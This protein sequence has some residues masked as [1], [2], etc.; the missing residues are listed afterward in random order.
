MALEFIKPVYSAVK[1]VNGQTGAVEIT[2]ESIGAATTEYVDN[3]VDKV[4]LTGLATEDY[5]EQRIKEVQVGGEVDLSEY[6]KKDEI[7]SVEGLASEQFVTDAIAAI[8]LTPGPQGEP[9]QDYVLTEEDLAEIASMVEV[10]GG[11]GDVDLSNYYTKDETYSREEVENAIATGYLCNVPILDN[12]DVDIST[13]TPGI[14]GI[15]CAVRPLMS[16][17]CSELNAKVNLTWWV[18]NGM[19]L[20][21]ERNVVAWGQD[22]A[23]LMFYAFC[24]EDYE[25]QEV[26]LEPTG[27]LDPTGW[28]MG[29]VSEGRVSEMINEA[30]G[31]VE[32]GSY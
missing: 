23:D 22:N 21:R 20:I 16:V 24:M 12:S 14:Y 15:N 9:G 31:V 6:A 4:D 2:A 5:V 1:S 7:P 11:G 27:K 25:G 13:V 26:T 10:S 17:L 3:A 29:A 18:S 30:L 28:T 19:L 8:E 32:N